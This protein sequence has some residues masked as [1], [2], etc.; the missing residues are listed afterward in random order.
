MTQSTLKWPVGMTLRPS[1][2]ISAVESMLETK[3]P[4]G[5]ADHELQ[6]GNTPV[7]ASRWAPTQPARSRPSTP[8]GHAPPFVNQFTRRRPPLAAPTVA[9]HSATTLAKRSATSGQSRTKGMKT[10]AQPASQL[11]GVPELHAAS[12]EPQHC[13]LIATV[14]RATPAPEHAA[15]ASWAVAAVEQ[16]SNKSGSTADLMATRAPLSLIATV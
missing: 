11:V 4:F 13:S 12:S 14:T 10:P 1:R 16:S 9:S 3:V 8:T 5:N 2:E 6:Q 15:A 7:M